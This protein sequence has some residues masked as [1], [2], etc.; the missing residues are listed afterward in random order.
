MD[1]RAVRKRWQ[2]NG[3]GP[4]PGPTTQ[5]KGLLQ[6]KMPR[7][8]HVFRNLPAELQNMIWRYSLPGP[9]VI[10]A[11]YIEGQDD[12]K[13]P[14]VFRDACPPTVLHVCK[15]SRQEALIFYKPLSQS[16]STDY[17]FEYDSELECDATD[18]DKSQVSESRIQRS[19]SIYFDPTLDTI[20]LMTPYFQQGPLY[21]EF[22][23]SFPDIKKIQSLAMEYYPGSH[24]INELCHMIICSEGNLKEIVLAVGPRAYLFYDRL[25]G[26]NIKFVEPKNDTLPVGTY[27]PQFPWQ[28]WKGI[29][30]DLRQQF[31]MFPSRPHFRVMEIEVVWDH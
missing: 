23:R 8:F 4:Y 31:E 14:F 15:S 3:K 13:G 19:R 20:Y 2:Q 7:T 18:D 30:D 24:T 5:Y 25:D 27:E 26:R 11:A 12:E 6:G 21:L 28:K 17:I 29:E 16:V 1:F 22:A 9:R 10:R